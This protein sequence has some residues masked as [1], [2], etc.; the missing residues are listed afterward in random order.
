[1]KRGY[2]LTYKD[3]L[4]AILF[5]FSLV[6]VSQ[7]RSI[8]LVPTFQEDTT[9]QDTILRFPFEDKSDFPNTNLENESPLYLGNPSNV[10][11]KIKYD[12]VRDEYIFVYKVGEME[13]RPSS[14]MS[15]EEYSQYDMEQAMRDYWRQSFKGEVQPAK[16]GLLSGLRIGGESI[17]EIFGSSA[18]N[19]IPQG[20]AELIF[21]V[22]INKNER[23]DISEELRS[24]TTFD[25]QEKIQL[26]VTGTIGDK[27]RVGVSYNTE[28]TFD[29]ENQTKLEYVGKED[30]II[31]KIEAGNVT[32]PL[33]GSL[34]TGSQSLFG[35][36][37]EL[38]FGN[39]TVTSVF[40]Q[41]EGE[42]KVIEI[43]GGAQTQEFDIYAD[44]YD[45]NRHFFLSHYFR[46][47]YNRA[48]ENL[49][50]INSNITITKVE[51]WVTNRRGE[52][53]TRNILAL[54][55][56]GEGR[57]NI[58]AEPSMINQN[59]I[60][61]I[62]PDNQLNEL[63]DKILAQSGVRDISQV[64]NVLFPFQSDGFVAGEDYEKLEHARKLKSNEFTINPRLGYISLNY[65]L[66]TDEILA[67]AYEYTV[68]GKKYQVGEFSTDGINAPELL[69]VKLLKG[70]NLSP[71]LPNWD[72]MMKN[73]YSMNAYQVNKD[74]FI[75]NILYQDDQTGNAINY[76]PEVSL[77]NP[78]LIK[79]IGLDKVNSQLDAMPD[80][81][82]DFIE[83]VTI[84]PSN[85]RI[86]FPVLEPFGED[87]RKSIGN[88][89]IAEKYVFDELYDTTLT[90]ARQIAEKNKF[91]I[92]GEYKSAVS[93]E[94]P[95][96]ALNIPQGSVIVTAGGR[97]LEENVEYT[98]DYNLGR[99]KIID[100]GLLESGTPIR[101]SLES[102]SLYNIQTKTLIGT[103]LD[104][105]FSDNFNVGATV[106]N[107]TE[108]P[109]TQK[110]NIGD[111]PISNTIWGINTSYRTESQF[112]TTL[113]DKLPFI[114]TKETSSIMFDAEFAQLIPGHSDVI[115]EEG[116]AY[117]DDF[118]GS[119]TSIDLKNINAWVLASTPQGQNDIFPEGG[120]Q[121]NLAYGYNRAHLSWYKIDPIF[122]RNG[123]STPDHI[124]RDPETQSS[125]YVREI[126]EKEIFPNVDY[127]NN[128][129]TALQVL[130]LA[131]Y[132]S[133]KG[134]YNFETTGEPGISDGLNSDGTLRDP[135]SRWGGIM[136]KI[137]SSD[138]DEQNIEYLEFWVMDPFVYDTM[139]NGGYLYFNLGDISEDILRD[140]RKS[141]EN[142]LPTPDKIQ[143]VDTT[144]WGVV[145]NTQPISNNFDNQ[146]TQDVGFDGLGDNDERNFHSNYLNSLNSLVTQDAVGKYQEDPSKDNYHY[147]LGGDYD[148]LELG[149]I[150]RYKLYN[151]TDGNSPI[152][153]ASTT[154]S[155]KSPDVE[156]INDDYTLNESES[157]YQ[158]RV[159]L[160]PDYMNVGENYIT[161]EIT[162]TVK[163]ANGQSS[164]IT[165][166]QFRIPV[167]DPDRTIGVMRSFKSI[168]FMRM[169]LQGFEDTVIIR[170][171]K[172]EL[173]RGEWRKYTYSLMAGQETLT[174]PEIS[175]GS[176]E[177]TS[178]NIEE[179]SDK[180]PI[181]YV[182]PPG[183]DRVIDPTNPQLRELNE[184][185]MVLKVRDLADG[186][187][188]A[189]YKNV[190]LDI[191]QYGKIKLFVHAEAIS[192]E[193]L[194]D[195]ELNVFV[196]LGTDYKDNY[197]EY[198][199]PVKVT[200]P[201]RYNNE[202]A[203][204]RRIVWPEGNDIVI[205]LSEFQ[206]IK[207]MRNNDVRSANS[208][209]H[210]YTRYS[211]IKGNSQ[212][213]VK[214]NPNLSNIKT[215]LIGVRNPSKQNNIR[216]D[217][218]LSKSGEIW[219][220]E[221]RLSD[222]NER[223]GWAAKGRLSTRL[224]DL[225]VINISGSTSTPGFGSIEKKV[226]ERSQEYTYIYDL[227]ANM[228]LGKFFSEESGVSIPVFANYSE[229]FINPE[230]NPLDPDIPMKD[231]LE[232]ATKEERDS[233]KDIAQDYTKRKSLNFTNVK[234]T[235]KNSKPSIFN[236]SN[237]SVSYAYNEI[238]SRNINTEYN[239]RKNYK[240]SLNYIYNSRPK[241][242][243]PFSRSKLLKGDLFRII[244]DFN[245]YYLPS[246]FSFST[247]INRD[248]NEIKTRNINNPGYLVEPTYSK[249]F[250]W[251]RVYNLKY[252]LS[253]SL[254]L[255][256]SATNIARIDEPE[257]IVNKDEDPQGYDE[258]RDSVWN[259]ILNFGRNTQYHH[260]I[261]AS[262]RIP[263]NKLPLLDWV[264][265]S[266]MYTANYG[267]DAGP[268]LADRDRD[269]GNT[270][271]N[272]STL[273]LSGQFNTL[274]LY[275]KVG[276]LKRINQKYARGR[277][278][279]KEYVKVEFIENDVSMRTDRRKSI[280]HDLKTEDITGVKVMKGPTLI[281]S[282]FE[283]ES[284][285]KIY[286]TIEQ[287]VDDA[288]VI[289]EG[290][291]E[292]GENVAVYL[293]ENLARI[294]MSIKSISISYSQTEGS[295]LS[296][297]KP[298]SELFGLDNVDGILS[299]G[300]SYVL[301]LQD[302]DFA[303]KAI[304]NNWMSLDTTLNTPYL[305]THNNNLSIRAK[306]QP[307]NWINIDV[308]A[309]RSYSENNNLYYLPGKYGDQLIDHNTT[310]N[311]SISVI[312]LGTAFEDITNENYFNDPTYQE[313]LENR[314][315]ISARLANERVANPSE[316]YD[317][318]VTDANGYHDGYGELSQDV[319]IPSFLAA[320]GVESVENISLDKF[321]TIPFPNWRITFTG[322]TDVAFL[323][324]FFKSINISHSYKSTYNVGS[325]INNPDY[326]EIGDGFSY[327]R[328]M[329]NNFIPLYDINAVSINE[330]FAPLINLDLNW[331]NNI[332]TRFEIKKSRLLTLSFANNQLSEMT[333]TEYVVSLG[334][335]FDDFNLILNFGDDQS[336]FASD[337]NIR[338]DFSLRDNMTVLRKL[339]ENI[340]EI[341]AGQ[342]TIV[343]GISADYM[344]SNRL[345]LRLFYDYN[346]NEPFISKSY[347]TSNQN[348]GLSFRFTLT[349]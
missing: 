347:P 93:S 144:I 128:V 285:N 97:K 242:I 311:F 155:R 222:F 69:L 279:K 71:A 301:G 151:G 83:G 181:N 57:G 286:V 315:I 127:E 335:R 80:G 220:N 288:Q 77:D 138:F 10:T 165:W 200:P 82:F 68:D 226:G 3:F 244:R 59:L 186:D 133:E 37:T 293:A 306:L 196:R 111:E 67:V 32:L 99:V 275:N 98:V 64:S 262:Y 256:F 217:D 259:S 106:L 304:Q 290:R 21:G 321:P 100:P 167:R 346:G 122:L 142:G 2:Y 239:I 195:D 65:A 343:I 344:I 43:K 53:E 240:G 243:A 211:I 149:I 313:F 47:N 299:P 184:Q 245:F 24:T 310:G 348:I 31:K 332:I 322:L 269:L 160:H 227:S 341:S 158:Y 20:S 178:V 44:E 113:I 219:V 38:Q 264:T 88:E 192:P 305:M 72:L 54:L 345:N 320:Y 168:R 281:E 28:A 246:N 121:N 27:I 87:L 46:E 157:Y 257:G 78:I 132:P 291:I 225:G 340:D 70:T 150:D 249:D 55:D 145:P 228:N 185:A 147:Y 212:I 325:F 39:L 319:L 76:L 148:A 94:I 214:G 154:S 179:N 161:D 34:I 218:G 260:E 66:N 63:Y 96:N 135:A 49:P 265:S 182:L 18:I 202:S 294:I 284:K 159:L 104:Y 272:S 307:F 175:T 236:L 166:Y 8:G 263:I 19:I 7:G 292:K 56:L 143:P 29:F 221:L 130:N 204:H 189:A 134:P 1:M 177:I 117:I 309:M 30:E 280:V 110:V 125:H 25:F 197:Y 247:Q 258:W 267:W 328:D 11:T 331:K 174:S 105:R 22:N 297:F 336:D 41:Q 89:G 224:A 118:E 206:N 278:K 314:E 273:N 141:F 173:V 287:D 326:Y 234:V 74:D 276:F 223:G 13:Y 266:A 180:D 14:I 73:I 282:E 112:L 42:T 308:S 316:N 45:A 131:F 229:T 237:F 312:T 230:Y 26:N 190:N 205:T 92:A 123:S 329:Q 210:Y 198:E 51:V 235:S 283:V 323:K 187:A 241:N 75:L 261:K 215:I 136:R 140:S 102:N 199:I 334:Y 58:H 253:R 255:E 254:K 109:L 330:Q 91:R 5:F 252:D 9:K 84:L 162:R 171:A 17:D 36:K 277:S 124:A 120:L 16:K 338:A 156:D 103:H 298:E 188:K 15:F 250:T 33:P 4:V 270:I 129:P 183:V 194:N 324:K 203:E 248:Y 114:E 327:V 81:R 303:Y 251:D 115:E 169:F 339:S 79:L 163:L 296:G 12:P 116:N 233:I 35:V 170:F 52:T 95:L 191:R 48:L 153:D 23:P 289:I 62:Y 176:F 126:F 208:D 232:N 271:R 268:I 86:I 139:S 349:Q 318:D 61:G 40:S 333:T 274:S 152:D 146:D 231:A 108:K 60:T 302:E 172:L 342:Q 300:I 193:M 201:G 317:P 213:T 238:Y 101:I 164:Q 207:E 50:V 337:L 85:G 6:Q 107:L 216:D 90:I 295:S 209:I 119:E 137:Q